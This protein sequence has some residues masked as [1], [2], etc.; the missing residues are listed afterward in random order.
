ML[1]SNVPRVAL[2]AAV[3]VFLVP[4]FFFSKNAPAGLPTA[5]PSASASASLAPTASP[6]ATPLTYT[7]K[8]NDTLTKI[9][10][11]FKTTQ[12]A[13][14]AANVTDPLVNGKDQPGRARQARQAG[15]SRVSIA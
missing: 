1:P 11:L 3:L 7:V 12:Q 5:S 15:V 9:A 8:A 14:L 6:K 10:K 2:G 13:I 4:A